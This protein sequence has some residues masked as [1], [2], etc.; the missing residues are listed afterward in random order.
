MRN[1]I[2]EPNGKGSKIWRSRLG[3]IA[4]GMILMSACGDGGS[5]KTSQDSAPVDTAMTTDVP[6]VAAS[7]R[8]VRVPEDHSTVQGAVDS[9]SEGDLILIG[10]GTY[11]EEVEVTTDNIVI[12]GLDRNEVILDGEFQK[13]NGIRV[14]GANGV[15]VENMTAMNY[16]NNGFLWTGV[17]G[18][19]GSYLTAWRNGDYGIYA[20]D[21]V[22]GLIEHSYAAGSTDAGIYIGQCY[23]CDAVLTDSISEHNALGYSGTNAGGNLFVINSTFRNNRMGIVPNSGTYE[24]CYPQRDTV[25]MGNS[26]YSNN[27]PDTPAFQ[28]AVQFMGTGIFTAGGVANTVAKNRVW[29]HDR[30]GIALVPY[31]EWSPN[32]II[33][34]RKYWDDSCAE[35]R[36]L[37]PGQPNGPLLWDTF[38]SRVIDNVIEDS[39][40]ADLT[41]ASTTTDISTLNNCF[42]NNSFTTSAPNDL[43]VLAPCDGTAQSGDWTDSVVDMDAWVNQVENVERGPKYKTAPLPERPILENM[44]DAATAPA[45]PASPMPPKVDIAAIRVPDRVD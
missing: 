32:D 16:R 14:V 13:A 26:V 7:G 45:V 42:S 43:E 19:R 34:D 17:T 2:A 27:Q 18:Y 8:V 20:F 37:L 9:A 40:L 31:V 44:P 4:A 41:L 12:R 39:G 25:I 24:L 1:V 15:A 38:D 6:G 35:T 10:P 22:G 33:P 23:P 30:L 21:A 36:N 3:V 5:T 28:W 11:K 29:D